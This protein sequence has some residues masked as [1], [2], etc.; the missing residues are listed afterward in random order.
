MYKV[1]CYFCGIGFCIW[2]VIISIL[3]H[4]TN[5]SNTM[6]PAIFISSITFSLGIF[7][8]IC[9]LHDYAICIALVMYHK[10]RES[11][12]RVYK[13]KAGIDQEDLK[14]KIYTALIYLCLTIC[15]IFFIGGLIFYHIINPDDWIRSA[16]LTCIGVSLGIFIGYSIYEKETGFWDEN[17]DVEVYY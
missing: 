10:E 2:F 17:F 16:V 15:V 14:N 11:E 13:L 9:V 8:G 5:L 1:L 12:I 3:C 7:L 6:G 4:I